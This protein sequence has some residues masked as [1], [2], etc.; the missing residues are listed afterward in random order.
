ML[1]M[2]TPHLRTA[3]RIFGA[4]FLLLIA[5]SSGHVYTMDD[6]TNFHVAYS[7]LTRGTADVT[8]AAEDRHLNVVRDGAGRAWSYYGVGGPLLFLPGIVVGRLAGTL[9]GREVYLA[10][11]GMAL[12][13]SFLTAFTAALIYFILMDAGR[14]SRRSILATGLY[15]FGTPALVWARQSQNSVAVGALFLLAV[16]LLRRPGIAWTVLAAAALGLAVNVR[17][18]AVIGAVIILLLGLADGRP[19][20]RDLPIVAATLVPFASVL[21]LYNFVRFGSPWTLGYPDSHAGDPFGTPI[22]E[23]LYGLVLSPG[24]GLLAYSPVVVFAFASGM[25][26]DIEG[27]RIFKVALTV[28]IA[29]LALYAK[30]RAWHGGL[31]WGPRY[32]ACFLPLIATGWA[33]MP[34]S[35]LHGGRRRILLGLFAI[36]FFIQ[37]VGISASVDSYHDLLVEKGIDP[38]KATSDP[39]LSP[40]LGNLDV[41]RQ[42][43]FDQSVPLPDE[44]I[45]PAGGHA[46]TQNL[47]FTPDFWPF[48]AVKVGVPVIPTALLWT[49][50][51]A[52]AFRFW[53]PMIAEFQRSD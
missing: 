8:E 40:I 5:L 25:P 16:A 44:G 6:H 35:W 43:R 12:T 17:Y 52:A 53:G 30:Y 15:L 22:L 10:Q 29:Y 37:L 18:D 21:L 38:L 39:L 24:V 41:V 14:T 20:I 3:C 23:G 28:T 32:L 51:M 27:R 46:S 33:W 7:F 36:S 1:T 34:E 45:L 26:A 11:A 13:N 47:R 2:M 9:A 50:L 49:V 42:F 4:S 31:G 48:Y 19:K